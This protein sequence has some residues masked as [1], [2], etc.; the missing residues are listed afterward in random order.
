MNTVDRRRFLTLLAGGSAAALFT[1]CGT[2]SPDAPLSGELHVSAAGDADFSVSAVG[3]DGAPRVVTSG[4]RGHGLA[5]HPRRP[6]SVVMVGRRP[7]TRCVEVDL[8]E[9]VVR[10]TFEAAPDRIFCGHGCFSADGAVFFTAEADVETGVGAIGVR[11]ADTWALLDRFESHGVGPHELR[12]MPDGRT[13]VVANG[14]LVEVGRTVVNLDS[15]HSNLAYVNA[16]DGALLESVGVAEAKASIRHLDV[17]ADGLVAFAMQVQREGM[18]HADTVPLA[19]LHRRGEAVRV[20]AEPEAVIAEMNDYMGSVAISE[21]S[22]IAAFTSPRGN[23][24]AFWSITS[25]AF[26]GYHRFADVCGAAVTADHTQFVLT[27][28]LGE[29]RR[30]DARTLAE[31]RAARRTDPGVRWDNHL[32]TVEV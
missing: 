25:G 26:V 27:N 31:D 15:M 7:G 24:A 9:G 21:A 30:L 6:E 3:R 29:L 28:S 18:A 10:H 16:A 11:D 20:L 12:L 19:A 17:T 13:L 5:Q 32:L 23:L 2:T 22:D 14:G 4:F 8:V 1:A